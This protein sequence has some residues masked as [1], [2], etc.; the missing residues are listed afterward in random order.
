MKQL[1]CIL[2]LGLMG[3]VTGAMFLRLV[4]LGDTAPAGTDGRIPVHMSAGERDFVLAE[5][6][7]FLAAVQAINAAALGNDISSIAAIAQPMGMSVTA[8]APKGLLGK[9]PLEFKLLG[10]AIH[11]DFDAMAKMADSGATSIEIQ[12]MLN[13][14]LLKCVA[15]H[16]GYR[17][18]VEK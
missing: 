8:H 1:L 18:E 16:A 9:L 6:R 4:I 17:I 13:D 14:S 11:D 12:R 7:D 5:M 2:A 10:F 15:C 3:A